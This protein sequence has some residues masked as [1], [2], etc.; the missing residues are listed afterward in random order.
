MLPSDQWNERAVFSPALSNLST[1]LRSL[2]SLRLNNPDS[3]P[4]ASA[5]NAAG[6]SETASSCRRGRAA[7]RR[8]PRATWGRPAR[9]SDLITRRFDAPLDMGGTGGLGDVGGLF[10]ARRTSDESGG[11]GGVLAQD[12]G[13][14]FHVRADQDESHRRM[15]RS[16]HRPARQAR[17]AV[18]GNY[19]GGRDDR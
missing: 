15:A 1:S 19:C 10:P 3:T 16:I 5:G 8:V 11:R 7:G 12:D 4:P 14:G 18:A 2:R 9:A 17:R 13:D 6:F